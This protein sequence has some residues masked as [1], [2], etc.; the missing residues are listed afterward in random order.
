MILRS[1]FKLNIDLFLFFA[2]LASSMIGAQIQG[3]SLP[4]I[5]LIPL[6]IYVFIQLKNSSIVMN[7]E[8]WWILGWF[9]LIIVSSYL[10]YCLTDSPLKGYKDVLL[11]NIIQTLIFQIPLLFLFSGINE[12]FE[13]MKKNILTVAKISCVWCFVQFIAWYVF[14]FDFNHFLFIDLLH[15]LLGDREWTALYNDGQVVSIRPTGF[16]HDPAFL[17]LLLVFGFILTNS[18]YWKYV[19]FMGTLAALSR[20]GIISIIAIFFYQKYKENSLNINI[21][22][23]ISGLCV[24]LAFVFATVLLYNNNSFVENQID[25]VIFRTVNMMNGKATDGSDRHLYYLPVA[26]LTCIKMPA[27]NIILGTGART[28]GNALVMTDAYHNFFTLNRTQETNS[29]ALE[30]DPAELLLGMG[31]V[32]FCMF[33]LIL[34]RLVKKFHKNKKDTMLFLVIFFFGIMY[35]VS[36]HPLV[37]LLFIIASQTIV[38]D[39]NF[40]ASINYST[41]NT[42]PLPQKGD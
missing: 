6:E 37:T 24:S 40:A 3:I 23:L 1:P 34:I 9:T 21:G 17:S 27:Y 15:G 28:G 25:K 10:N 20:V 7:R 38:C 14:F 39:N 18:K 8:K 5:A 26:I 31:V 35:D 13:K 32:G 42:T 19:F 12:A 33:Y 30:C 36:A 41:N 11:L 4:K 16:T 22:K 2:V 29:W